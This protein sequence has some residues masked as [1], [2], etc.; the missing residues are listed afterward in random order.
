MRQKNVVQGAS[1]FQQYIILVT[2]A[3]ITE[4]ECINENQPLVKGD[5]LANI[6]R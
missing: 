5:N 1:S 4:N 3:E 2:F 6:V